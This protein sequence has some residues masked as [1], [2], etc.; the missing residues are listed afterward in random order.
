MAG[1]VMVY[2]IDKDEFLFIY[3]RIRALVLLEENI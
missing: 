1:S 2:V 3:L